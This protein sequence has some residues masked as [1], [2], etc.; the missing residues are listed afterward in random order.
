MQTD[1]FSWSD[2]L[3]RFGLNGDEPLNHDP[4]RFLVPNEN[5][6]EWSTAYALKT[7][8]N[9]SVYIASP[10]QMRFDDENSLYRIIDVAGSFESGGQW[11]KVWGK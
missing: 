4:V 2:M 9:G 7:C 11:K 8:D 5:C 6:S 3:E 10:V 1:W